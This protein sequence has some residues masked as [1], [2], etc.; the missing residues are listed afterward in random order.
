MPRTQDSDSPHRGL[1]VLLRR[2]KATT[3]IGAVGAVMV[4]SH[5]VLGPSV[6]PVGVV[7]IGVALVG[8]AA[9]RLT[10]VRRRDE[11]VADRQ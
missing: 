11:R 3:A 4:A 6:V 7:L 10:R 8:A 9:L 1:S 5:L 2:H